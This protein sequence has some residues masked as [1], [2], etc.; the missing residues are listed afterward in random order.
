M[1]GPCWW[2]AERV[3]RLLELKERDAVW[4]DITESGESGFRAL[5]GLLGLVARRQAALWMDLRPWI[6]PG[7]DTLDGL[8]THAEFD[9]LGPYQR[10]IPLDVRG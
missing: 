10:D 8:A 4:G 9:S 6:A 5:S 2:L 3:S 7:L 1:S